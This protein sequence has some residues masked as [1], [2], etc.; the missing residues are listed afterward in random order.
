MVAGCGAHSCHL[1]TTERVKFGPHERGNLIL[2]LLVWIY[3][4]E[5]ANRRAR[6]L[7]QARRKPVGVRLAARE[8]L[9]E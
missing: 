8:V 9:R 5:R 3:T 4:G 1:V 2:G 7:V 6:H